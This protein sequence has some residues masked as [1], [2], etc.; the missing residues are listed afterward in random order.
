MQAIA[1]HVYHILIIAF[2]AATIVEAI[3]KVDEILP[4]EVVGF[5]RGFTRLGPRTGEADGLRWL[6][7]EAMELGERPLWNTFRVLRDISS[8]APRTSPIGEALRAPDYHDSLV[9]S[10]AG[11]TAGK[12]R[13]H[14][15][16]CWTAPASPIRWEMRVPIDEAVAARAGNG[17]RDGSVA[18]RRRLP[19]VMIGRLWNR[20]CLSRPTVNL[21]RWRTRTSPWSRSI[22][23][24]SCGPWGG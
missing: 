17:T 14:T 20:S 24:R 4:S 3:V 13:A 12:T 10:L 23:V 1:D 15:C 16:A 18:W 2:V 19:S 7:A 21:N 22:R 6:P 9:W 11:K 8:V 5:V